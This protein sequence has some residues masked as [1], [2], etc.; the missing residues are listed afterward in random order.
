VRDG[1]WDCGYWVKIQERRSDWSAYL[2]NNLSMA[3]IGQSVSSLCVSNWREAARGKTL[4]YGHAHWLVAD[5]ETFPMV[6]NMIRRLL[7]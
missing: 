7:E 2:L 6:Y 1:L 5:D 4:L 3:V